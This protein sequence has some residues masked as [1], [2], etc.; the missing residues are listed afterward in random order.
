MSI[1][2]KKQKGN[3]EPNGFSA[4]MEKNK[5]KIA[6]WLNS[7]TKGC[8]PRFMKTALIVFCIL[9]GAFC[10]YTLFHAVRRPDIRSH[11]IILNHLRSGVQATHYP[12]VSD[13]LFKHVRRTEQWLDS[14]RDNDTIKL[15]AI[16]LA[17]PYLL[18]NL[19][20]IERIYQSQNK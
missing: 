2:F 15:K 13:S 3:V 18:T 4:A 17:K 6:G 12:P 1:F 8:P 19:Q 5:L 16:L 20:L 14:L 7:K 9:F 11:I 10:F